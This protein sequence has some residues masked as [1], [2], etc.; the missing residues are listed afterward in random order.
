MRAGYADTSPTVSIL[1][2]SYNSAAWLEQAV[3]S[4]QRQTLTHWECLI[5][6]DASP[7]NATQLAAHLAEREPRVRALRHS[8]N[9]GVSEALNTGIRAAR[10]QYIQTLGADDIIEPSKLEHQAGVLDANPDVGLVY[11]DACY[12]DD[13]HPHRLRRHRTDDREWMPC[14]SGGRE[15]VLP[16]LIRRNILPYQAVLFRGSVFDTVGLF[17]PHL[18][19]HEDYDM[20]LRIAMADIPFAYAPAPRTR[21][22]VRVHPG[23]LTNQQ[24]QMWETLVAVRD[25]ADAMLVD[26]G[27]RRLN[28]EM[29]VK[30]LRNLASAHTRRGRRV[31]AFAR[32][33]WVAPYPRQKVGNLVRAAAAL[34]RS[35]SEPACDK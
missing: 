15:M 33:S 32:A 10:G 34:L 19:S 21:V 16:E 35:P 1:L 26:A 27:L 5:V 30:E 20:C 9:R 31:S 23:A 25:K 8:T 14:V 13:S 29:Q 22:L 3:L 4:Y 17:D 2:P 28:R 7:D 11:G 6:D 24:V 18:R 12:F